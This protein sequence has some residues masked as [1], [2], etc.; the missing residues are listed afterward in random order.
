M[1]EVSM[2]VP[3]NPI[4]PWMGTVVGSELDSTIE[5][6]TLVALATLCESHLAATVEVPTTL[7]PIHNQEDPV[8]HQCLVT[9]SGSKGSHFHDGVAEM[10]KYAKYL[11]NLQHNTARTVV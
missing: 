9:M 6:M 5:Q 3:F 8:W 10:A 7:F 2:M 11:F 1:W 4:D